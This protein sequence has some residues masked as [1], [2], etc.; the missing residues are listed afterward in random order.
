MKVNDNGGK[1]TVS[2]TIDIPLIF[3]AFKGQ[4]KSVLEK[5]LKDTLG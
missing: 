5:K 4:V 2:M 1:S 3:A